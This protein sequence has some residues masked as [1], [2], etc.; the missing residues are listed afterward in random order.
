MA[1][2]FETRYFRPGT[3]DEVVR[4][5]ATP[6]PVATWASDYPAAYAIPPHCH[7]RS[8]L[9]YSLTGVAIAHTH[10]RHWLVPTD[11]ALWIPARTEHSVTM[12]EKTSARS[13][14]VDTTTVPNLPADCRIFHVSDLM[15]S[16]IVEAV[17]ARRDD[18][19]SNRTRLI[20]ALIVEELPRLAE[21][22]L[23]LPLPADPRLAARCRQFLAAPSAHDSIDEWAG[24]MA[25]SRSSF[26]RAFRRETGLSFSAWRQQACLF[27]ALP[28][29]SRGEGITQVALDLGYESAAAFT[30][31]FRRMLGEPPAR[32]LRGQKHT[33][34]V[35]APQPDATIADDI[36]TLTSHGST[37]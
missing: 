22:P 13:L 7:S 4:I 8:Q 26:T 32:Y 25:M 20:L 3:L 28:R 23:A 9:L 31:M 17:K 27:A 6:G 15:R 35:Y 18:T 16:L 33:D 14:Y 1:G 11:H 19:G 12:L 29:L 30:T 10:G 37:H 2:E 21:A 5:E 36:A 24:D 34:P